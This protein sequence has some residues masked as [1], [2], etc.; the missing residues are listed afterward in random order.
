MSTGVTPA[1]TQDTAFKR[2]LPRYK[3]AI[4][5]D[6]TVLR[7]GVPDRISGSSIEIGEGGMGIVA[8]S[9]LVVG[10]SVRVEFLVPH[11]S[12][13]MRATAVV[14]YQ[15]DKCFG[16]QFL[17][18]PAAQ[19]LRIR[20]WTRH[21]GEILLASQPGASPEHEVAEL[22]T[23]SDGSENSK[24][25][26]SSRR[27]VS[28]VLCAT[29]LAAVLGW[30]HWQRGWTELEKQAPGSGTVMATPQLKVPPDTMERRIIHQ[31]APEYPVLARQARVQ[32][33]VVLDAVVN[34]DGAVTQVTPV[35]GPQ[36][37]S[38][39]AMD[40]VR[41][42]RYEPYLVNGQPTT[43]ETTIAVNFRLAN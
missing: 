23:D 41:W 42:W 7:S 19:Q 16:L 38:Q 28:L 34:A 14:R 30:W 36:A 8:A 27:M 43:V 40:A 37:L 6:L 31:V 15:R 5:L 9:Q 3:L 13:P 11:M 4:P 18:L 39:S 35:S 22:P 10:E 25:R 26:F 33:T 1:F 21:E 32:G 17:R 20:Y 12:S 29:V 24:R 2:R